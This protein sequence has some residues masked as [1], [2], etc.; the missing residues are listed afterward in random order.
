MA[1][2]S[3]TV[4]RF[5]GVRIRLHVTLLLVLPYLAYTI[6][7][8]FQA[9]VAD[10]G[11]N[12]ESLAFQ[13]SPRGPWLWG[14][15]FALCLFA[16][17][18]AH[19]LA[20]VSVAIRQGA[21][22]K[23]ILLMMLGGV[24][25]IE[26]SDEAPAKEARLALIG[27]AA[28]LL[29]SLLGW[30]LWRKSGAGSASFFGHWIF[31]SNLVLAIFNLLPA[32]PLDGGR[33][34]RAS[35]SARIGKVRATRVAVRL[36]HGFAWILGALGVLGFNLF[37][38]LIAFFLYA[39]AQAEWSLMMSRGLLEGMKAGDVATLVPPVE[40]GQ[41]LAEA[42]AQML[43]SRVTALPVLHPG[44]VLSIVTLQ[45]LRSVPFHFRDTTR[46]RDIS[47]HALRGESS[48]V[49]FLEWDTPLH[50]ALNDLASAP[51][52][53]LPVMA[54][55]KVIGILR[56]SDLSEVLQLRSLEKSAA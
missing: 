52:A 5:K 56:Y 54:H 25:D 4:A 12:P 6:A 19:E 18:L 36:S 17:V 24:S 11:V 2:Q 30:L 8:R 16:S 10:A 48:R 7:V 32:F 13:G 50:A 31:Q 38:V 35:L 46:I 45:Q 39:S 20:H 33:A 40:E 1:T 21:K 42:I 37:L 34:F 3:W 29:I 49:E 41:T 47:S 27:P 14:T 55:G 23:S 43:H 28:S 15:L 53:T 26:E 22:V 9:L 44:G 51:H